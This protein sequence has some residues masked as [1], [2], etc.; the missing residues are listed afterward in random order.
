M[1]L[2]N[3]SAIVTGGAGGF[4]AATVRRFARMGAQV[5]IA[6]ISDDRAKALAGEIGASCSYVRTDCMDQADIAAAIDTAAGLAPLR[7]AVITHMGP[8][9]PGGR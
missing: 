4:G 7:A 9:P 3:A 6:D 5:V 1:D 8:P 2:S